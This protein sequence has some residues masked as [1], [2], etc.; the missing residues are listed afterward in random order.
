MSLHIRHITIPIATFFLVCMNASCTG[1]DQS[2]PKYEPA[3]AEDSSSDKILTLCVT[4]LASYEK[5]FEFCQYLNKRL[6]ES[7]RIQVVATHGL[8]DFIQKIS[9]KKFAIAL[10]SGEVAVQNLK[11]AYSVV[12]KYENDDD[13]RGV[14]ITRKDVSIKRVSDLKGKTIACPGPDVLAGTKLPL[15]YLATHGLDLNKDLLITHVASFESV[16][17]NVY[18]R[19]SYAG[20]SLLSR[21]KN[22]AKTKPEIAEAL[23][24]QFVTET[25]P[26]IAM[27]IRNDI[28]KETQT[29]LLDLIFDMNKNPEGQKIFAEI[30]MTGFQ[31]A[32]AD[33][34]KSVAVF[35][36][37]YRKIAP[38]STR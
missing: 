30:G 24:S 7:I 3:Y 29:K 12:A 32:N 38:V 27:V 25:L 35:L 2:V 19:K 34:Y 9:K 26:N 4:S 33:T 13:Y 10:I 22:F 14:I 37:K 31:K 15:Y 1:P 18:L 11:N 28:P 21:W 16:Y 23:T 5:Y 6:P 8:A 20:T 17:M 36:D